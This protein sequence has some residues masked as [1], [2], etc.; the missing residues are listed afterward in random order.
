MILLKECL[1]DLLLSVLI[2]NPFVHQFLEK[3]NLF[4]RINGIAQRFR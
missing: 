4:M 1:Y 2:G 3:V